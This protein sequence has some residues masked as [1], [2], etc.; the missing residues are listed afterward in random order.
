MKDIKKY[1]FGDGFSSFMGSSAGQNT[2]SGVGGLL[3]SLGQKKNANAMEQEQAGVRNAISDA[4]IKSGNPI[5]MAIGAGAKIID[6]IGAKTGLNLDAVDKKTA[7]KAGAG[8]AAGFNNFMNYLPGNSM[9]WGMWAG[10][11]TKADEISEEVNNISD[12]FGDSVD[13]LYGAKDLGNK[14][15]L[16]GRGKINKYINA[17]NAMNERLQNLATTNTYRKASDYGMDIAQQ[18]LNRYAGTNYM[19]NAIGKNGMK[20]IP[21]S[22]AKSI[23]IKRDLEKLFSEKQI[24]NLQKF[25]E[26]GKINVIPEGARH[27]RLNNLGDIDEKLEGMTKKGIPVVIPKEDGTLE[28]IAEVEC[29]EII[30]R[31]EVTDKLEELRKD[32][33]DKAAIEAGKLLAMEIITNTDDKTEKLLEEK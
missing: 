12:A 20:L 3:N 31:K 13:D 1:G 16:F 21:V 5:A 30:L 14:R 10:K 28:Q 9:L 15:M 4:A 11:T 24:E 22:R 19:Y 2:M 32:G 25:A 7:K 33:S 29:G 27:S 6:A 23:I 18:N 8:A 17:Q 26:G